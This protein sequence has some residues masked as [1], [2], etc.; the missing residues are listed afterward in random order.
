VLP[1]VPID[2]VL[3]LLQGGE[4]KMIRG[5]K[6]HG[7]KDGHIANVGV[8][9]RLGAGVVVD[10]KDLVPRPRAGATTAVEAAEEVED[11]KP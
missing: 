11:T 10:A 6:G 8:C 3:K 7:L 4:A 9:V 1:H 2:S 5:C